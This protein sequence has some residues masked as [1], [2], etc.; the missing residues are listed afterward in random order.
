MSKNA[1]LVRLQKE[2]K[3]LLK[4]PMNGIHALPS[5]DD[6]SV[7]YYL[8]TGPKNTPFENGQYFGKVVFPPEYPYAPPAVYMYTPNG[9]FGTNEKVCMSMTD[10][11]PETWNPL[12]G[13]STI[14]PA[15][16]SFMTSPA[17]TLLASDTT[18]E[19]K[20]LLARRS[21]FNNLRLPAYRKYFQ[22]FSTENILQQW[23]ELFP[24]KD[25]VSQD[26]TDDTV[27][28]VEEEVLPIEVSNTPEGIETDTPA[29]LSIEPPIVS[30][31]NSNVKR[32]KANRT[33]EMNSALLELIADKEYV[34]INLG[35]IIFSENITIY[36][37]FVFFLLCTFSGMNQNFIDELKKSSS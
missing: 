32:R 25:I 18:D 20:R 16:V 7:W 34:A 9:C 13:I 8:A 4:T 29:N 21:I 19:D 35:I 22:E 36:F 3:K 31:A 1:G 6:M 27:E 26:E 10:L 2:Y 23:Q 37:N 33:N 14:L 11:H 28:T 12:W 15:L 5:D 30:P 24:S 17:P